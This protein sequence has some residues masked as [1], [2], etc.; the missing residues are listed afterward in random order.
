MSTINA[1]I[2]DKNGRIVRVLSVN[3]NDVALNML[4][5]QRYL[6]GHGEPSKQYVKDG[7]ILD[8]PEK[9][10]DFYIFDYE[11]EIWVVDVDLAEAQA[12]KKRADLLIDVD[13]INPMWWASMTDAERAEVS[14]YR[15]SLLDITNQSGY[16]TNIEW[17]E[18]PSVFKG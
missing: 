3:E 2:Y 12:R 13:K 10:A 18:I 17:P 6:V 8:L 14:A 16:P 15:Q 4:P 1:T 5:D 7:Q 9:P 11:S